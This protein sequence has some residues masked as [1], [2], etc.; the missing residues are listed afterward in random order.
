MLANTLKPN[1]EVESAD[2]HELFIFYDVAFFQGQLDGKVLLEW[3]SR[4]TLCAGIC[5]CSQMDRSTGRGLFCT[6]RLS[7]KL[8][9]LR[10]KENLLETLLHEMIHAFLFLTKTRHTRND[11]QDG[12]GPDFIEKML[13]V[14]EVTGLRLSV[15]H[16]F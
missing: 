7:K 1:R 10:S 3:S 15:Y 16:S 6:I 14:N 12:H 5:Y 9:V 4:M 13:E 11:G 8:L 2:I